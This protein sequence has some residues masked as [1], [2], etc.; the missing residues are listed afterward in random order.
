[1][2]SRKVRKWI[3]KVRADTLPISTTRL[4]NSKNND[5]AKL[6]EPA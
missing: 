4:N 5:D 1:M 3:S 6:I 2:E